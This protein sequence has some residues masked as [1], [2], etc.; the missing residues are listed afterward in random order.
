MNTKKNIRR[1][2]AAM[3]RP[4][5]AIRCPRLSPAGDDALRAL[6]REVRR[7]PVTKRGTL[8]VVLVKDLIRNSFDHV[9]GAG[10]W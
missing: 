5:P 6:V 2:L 9:D 3:W 10:E 7:L 8:L 1:E 4:E